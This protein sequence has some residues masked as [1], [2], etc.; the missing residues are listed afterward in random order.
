MSKW[1]LNVHNG[2]CSRTTFH[3]SSA[4]ICCFFTCITWSLFAP[5]WNKHAH[6]SEVLSS[7]ERRPNAGLDQEHGYEDEV[8]FF[9]TISMRNI[10]SRVLLGAGFQ[11]RVVYLSKTSLQAHSHCCLQGT[12]LLHLYALSPLQ[13][14]FWALNRSFSV[15][16]YKL[17]LS[18]GYF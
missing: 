18:S 7:G 1:K 15:W 8:F 17:V 3:L 4:N 14:V 16:H 13:S 10:W 11:S 12:A 2:R 5:C 6:L 9:R